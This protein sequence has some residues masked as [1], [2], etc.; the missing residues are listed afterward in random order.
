MYASQL[1]PSGDKKSA[2][3]FGEYQKV[4]FKQEDAKL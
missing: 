1:V 4:V 2:E 3:L